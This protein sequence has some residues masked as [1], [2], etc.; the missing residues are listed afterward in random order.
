MLKSSK[1]LGFF[2]VILTPIFISKMA[3]YWLVSA[4][5]EKTPQ[6]TYEALKARMVGL[7]PVW[8]FSIPELKV[9]T[10]M[11]DSILGSLETTIFQRFLSYSG[12]L[13]LNSRTFVAYRNN[14]YVQSYLRTKLFISS[15]TVLNFRSCDVFYKL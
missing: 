3:E 15:F 8:K 9:E 10:P 4:P 14:Y 5:G 2:P 11:S 1:F 12:I 13:P 6:Q 7:S